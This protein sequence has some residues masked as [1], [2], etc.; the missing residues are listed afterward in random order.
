[1]GRGRGLGEP[2]GNAQTELESSGKKYRFIKRIYKIMGAMPTWLP[3]P[4]GYVQ[5]V[6]KTLCQQGSYKHLASFPPLYIAEFG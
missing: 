2:M 1:M 5:R 4:F 3:C 6:C